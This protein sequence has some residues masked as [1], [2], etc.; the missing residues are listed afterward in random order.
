MAT[1]PIPGGEAI[2]LVVAALVGAWIMHL[3]RRLVLPRMQLTNMQS[4]LNQIQQAQNFSNQLQQLG[5][6][7]PNPIPPPSVPAT[8][9]KTAGQ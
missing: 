9:Q 7:F 2:G 3:I 8:D 5:A 6:G 1:F 4:A